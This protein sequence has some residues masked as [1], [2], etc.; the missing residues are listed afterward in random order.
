MDEIERTKK[1]IESLKEEIQQ[2]DKQIEELVGLLKELEWDDVERDTG[3]VSCSICGFYFNDLIKSN[4]HK[5]GCR[6]AKAIKGE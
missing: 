6:L 1:F 2:K 3:A 5:P 4:T